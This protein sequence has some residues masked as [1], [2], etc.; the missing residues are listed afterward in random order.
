M[1]I[2]GMMRSGSTLIDL[3]VHQLPDHFAVGELH[4]LWRNGVLLD[5]LCSCGNAFSAC[6][7]WVAVG[8]A[9]YGGWDRIDVEHVLALIQSVDRTARAPLI[10]SPRRPSSFERRLIEYRGLLVKLY[11]AITEVSGRAVVADSSKR[12]S[13]AFI[14]AAT[15]EIDLS[16]LHMLRDPRG[17]AFSFAK[18]IDLAPGVSDK[19][20]MTQRSTLKVGRQWV[21]VNEMISLAARKRPSVRVRYEDLVR[22]PQAELRRIA[23]CEG[24]ANAD[25][26]LSWLTDRG[27]VVPQ[28]H[29]VAGGRIRLHDGLMPLRVDDAW[30]REMPARA[31][32]L[33][34]A[35][36]W[37]SRR[38]Y[39]Y[40]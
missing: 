40:R 10:L 30:K 14:L 8:N 35:T 11:R 31:R 2:G 23:S 9:A 1:Y 29:I 38:H 6:P 33:I 32:H 5:G 12:P 25:L 27:M 21:T 7:F 26:D 15:E 17:V 3:M 13:L 20:T 34:E 4:Y 22:D 18:H 39:R 24:I 36:T 37:A 19:D 16:I 28:T